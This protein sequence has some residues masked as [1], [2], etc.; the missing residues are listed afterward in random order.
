MRIT[1]EFNT[2][3]GLTSREKD[4][5][6]LLAKLDETGV[7]Q[8]VETTMPDESAK[9]SSTKPARKAP[10]A[11]PAPEPEPEPS[12]PE[13]PEEDDLVG[14]GDAAPEYTMD[15]AVAR[16]TSMVGSGK[17]ADAKAA[18]VELGAKRV[19]ELTSEQ[20]QAFMAATKDAA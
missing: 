1:V 4:I 17:H 10:K 16:V 3:H 20:V 15:D 5:V 11:K 8:H 2:E 12:A 9:A 18:L 6:R 7:H 13:E 19:S 14:G